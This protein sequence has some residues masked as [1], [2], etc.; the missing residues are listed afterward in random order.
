[1]EKQLRV[2]A[3]H[4]LS[5]YGR[6]A[7]T[8]ILP[9]ISAMG[10]QC[11]TI[12]TAI[13]STHTG[14]FENFVLRDTTDFISPCCKHYK[15]LGVHFN[16]VYSGFLASE[17]QVDCCL[18]FFESF[19][20]ALRIVDPVMGDDGAA[21]QTYTK[22]LIE[23]TKELA[24]HADIITPNLT[25]AALLLDE[26]YP[27]GLTEAEARNWAERLC[28]KAGAT[29]ITGVP[30]TDGTYANV[31]MDGK[32]GCFQLHRW[33]KIPVS[34][35]GTGDI[36]ASVFT[37]CILKRKTIAEAAVYASKFCELAINATV[38]SGEPVRNG[39][40]FERVLSFLMNGEEVTHG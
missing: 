1:M 13:L 3:I 39:V 37:G 2:A 40:E 10:I 26:S 18:E 36:F 15:E 38:N 34:Y 35:P 14:G 32:N 12:P 11:V 4:D 9:V 8:V 27:E 21:Y 7:L 19:P 30:L 20:E 28:K 5:G 22:G 24:A 6:C 23:R 17:A 16:A 25:E 29:V 31:S 33:N